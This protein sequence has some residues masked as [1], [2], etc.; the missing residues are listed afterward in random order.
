MNLGSKG[1]NKNDT[2]I[3]VITLESR[4]FQPSMEPEFRYRVH[5]TPPLVLILGQ[6]NPFHMAHPIC[7]KTIWMLSSH[8]SLGLSCYNLALLFPSTVYTVQVY[9][10]VCCMSSQSFLCIV[11]RRM[12]V[13]ASPWTGLIWLRI[14]TSGGLLWHSSG[15]SGSIK[16]W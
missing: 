10:Y 11:R 6:I 3:T 9:M 14:G 16:C 12:H 13:D 1:L 15:P 7:F 4:K 5:K 2:G 8:L